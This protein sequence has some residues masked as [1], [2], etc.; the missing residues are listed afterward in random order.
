[1]FV[2][3]YTS[4]K[5]LLKKMKNL[6]IFSCLVI[7]VVGVLSDGHHIEEMSSGNEKEYKLENSV[8]VFKVLYTV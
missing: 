2:T 3:I 6:I 5:Q 8:K 7:C 4:R 1:M